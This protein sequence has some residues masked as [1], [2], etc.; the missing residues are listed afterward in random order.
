MVEMLVAVDQ[1]LGLLERELPHLARLVMPLRNALLGRVD[2]FFAEQIAAIE[3]IKYSPRKRYGVFSFIGTLPLF[4]SHISSIVD[5][6]L[7]GSQQAGG[8]GAKGWGECAIAKE[9]VAKGFERT[10]AC[11]F[12]CL[13]VLSQEADRGG[14]EKERINASVMIIRKRLSHAPILSWAVPSS[15]ARRLTQR[16]A[17]QCV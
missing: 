14:D 1:R 17:P 2:A 12:R 4:V 6:S 5:G 7:S 8:S 13:D 10:S 3:A 9:Y 15:L 11:I 16:C